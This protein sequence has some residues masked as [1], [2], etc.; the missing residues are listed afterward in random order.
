MNENPSWNF[1]DLYDRIVH[2]IFYEMTRPRQ[3]R[4]CRGPHDAAARPGRRGGR[5]DV[6]TAAVSCR[7]ESRLYGK[8]IRRA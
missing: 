6:H 1:S 8:H 7:P 2:T 3:R 5:G 4:V